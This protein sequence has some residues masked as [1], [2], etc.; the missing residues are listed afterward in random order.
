MC[1]VFFF[2]VLLNVIYVSLLLMIDGLNFIYL[3]CYFFFNVIEYILSEF[4][5]LEGFLSI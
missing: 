2:N 5:C 1:L 3:F 4:I